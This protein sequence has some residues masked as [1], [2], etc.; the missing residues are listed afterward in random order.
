MRRVFCVRQPRLVA[1]EILSLPDL[2][3]SRLNVTPREAWLT[4]RS[5]EYVKVTLAK[6]KAEQEKK[7]T[8]VEHK[9]GPCSDLETH[10]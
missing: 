5:N 3:Q 1:S 6:L 2:E 4:D 10:Y 8:K 9:V 7:G